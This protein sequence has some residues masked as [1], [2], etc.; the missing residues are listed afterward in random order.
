MCGVTVFYLNSKVDITQKNIQFVNKC[1]EFECYEKYTT[2]KWYYNIAS[3]IVFISC[4][5]KKKKKMTFGM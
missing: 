1:F 4:S 3:G 2:T 5:D